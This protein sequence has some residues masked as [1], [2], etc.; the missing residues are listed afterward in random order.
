LVQKGE[1]WVKAL[2]FENDEVIIDPR[3]TKLRL[4][5]FLSKFKNLVETK[6]LFRQSGWCN[7]KII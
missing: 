5:L 2:D 4:M 1:K 3:V 6:E 7:V